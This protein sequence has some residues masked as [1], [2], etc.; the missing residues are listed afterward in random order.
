MDW[1]SIRADSVDWEMNPIS[2]RAGGYVRMMCNDI[3]K[4]KGSHGVGCGDWSELT[5]GDIADL[6]ERHWLRCTNIGPLGVK[7]IK[8]G[9]D[10]AAIG[11]HPVLATKGKAVDAY[12]PQTGGES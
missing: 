8:W 10:Q 2:K 6:G 11:R 9:I 7:V 12:E 3:F 4:W 5:L 1:R